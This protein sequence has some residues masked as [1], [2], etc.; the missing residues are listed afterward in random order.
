MNGS[1]INEVAEGNLGEG[2]AEPWVVYSLLCL[3]TI[4]RSGAPRG[5]IWRIL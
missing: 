4:E 3:P 5:K 1:R 2:R